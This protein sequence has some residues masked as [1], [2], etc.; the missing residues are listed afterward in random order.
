MCGQASYHPQEMSVKHASP[1]TRG[2][3]GIIARMSSQAPPAP[4][5]AETQENTPARASQPADGKSSRRRRILVGM[6]IYIALLLI[7]G[8]AAYWQGQVLGEKQRQGELE[9][10]LQEQYEL[11]IADLESGR[12]ALA[13]QRFEAIIHEA[14][15]FPGAEDRLVE[16]LLHLDVPTLTPTP[17]PTATPDPSPPEKLFEDAQTALDGG[18]WHTVIDKLLSLRAKDPT[19]RAVEGDGMMFTALRNL[20]MKLIAQGEMEEGLYQLS[21]AEQFGPLDRDA[22][23]R[24]SLAQQYLLANSYIGLNWARAAELFAPLCQQGATSDSCPKY[25]EAAWKYGDLLWNAGEACKADQQYQASLSA[26]T[27]PELEPTASKARRVCATQSA[28]PPQPTATLTPTPT[29]EGGGAGNG[30]G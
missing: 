2:K 1:E 13:R 28:P 3:Y 7:A 15:E 4:E 18:D 16:A 14:P 6:A 10:A 25:A 20:G 19:Y 29:Q 24:R 9:R 12:Y 11:G 26:F 27:F 5:P 30:G 8:G 17:R 22:I 23:F 21:L